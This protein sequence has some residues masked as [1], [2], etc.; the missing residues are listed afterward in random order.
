MRIRTLKLVIMLLQ[1][2]LY[3]KKIRNTIIVS[4]SLDADQGQHSVGPH[5][6]PI[7]LQRLSADIKSCCQQRKLLIWEH[8]F[9]KFSFSLLL[10]LIEV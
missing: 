10:P 2:L 6:G 4:N 9:L 3:L 5:L 7:C 8:L 1:K